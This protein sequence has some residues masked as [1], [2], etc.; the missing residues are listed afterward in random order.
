MPTYAIV[1]AT[2]NCGRA[3]LDNLYR[4]PNANVRAYC[5]NKS[6]LLSL[7]PHLIEDERV[8]IFEGGIG[9]VAL[10]SQCIKGT[11]AIFHVVS[12]NTNVPGYN[13]G[14]ETAK[15]IVAAL[16]KL[17]AESPEEKKLPK[18]LLLSS[19]TIDDHLSRRMPWLFRTI[20]LKSASYVYDDLRRTEA[21]IRQRQD[22]VTTIFIKP[23]GLS[24]DE[25]RG[26]RLDFDHEE[27]FISYLDLAA[28]MIE[29]ADDPSGR[30][31]MKNI[32]VV[33]RAGSAKFPPGTPMCILTGLLRHYVPFLHGY[34]PSTGPA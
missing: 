10:L 4:N 2:G 32:S 20:L 1:G 7:V 28:A 21:F 23:G 11:Q 14:L 13:V 30:Y 5:R 24:V 34:L 18:L 12:T 22:T 19:A 31:D 26:H 17:I 9:D 15:S 16:D 3:L 27:S 6:K 33:N 25:Q 8:Q 29:A